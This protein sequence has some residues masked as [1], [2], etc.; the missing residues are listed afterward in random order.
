MWYLVYHFNCIDECRFAHK[1]YPLLLKADLSF[2]QLRQHHNRLWSYLKAHTDF[3]LD[4]SIVVTDREN[5]AL[6]ATNPNQI[7]VPDKD[8]A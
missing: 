8:T 4:E 2:D 1:T 6:V 3:G 7:V 5:E